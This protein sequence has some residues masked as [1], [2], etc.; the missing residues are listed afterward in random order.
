MQPLRSGGPLQLL[1]CML[2]RWAAGP[3]PS[4][5]APVCHCRARCLQI[6]PPSTTGFLLGQ[7][8]DLG[9]KLTSVVTYHILPTP[10]SPDQVTQ[11]G[12]LGAA[13]EGLEGRSTAGCS[14]VAAARWGAPPGGRRRLRA[15][16]EGP[17]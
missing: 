12:A 4:M 10:V 2:V 1:W 8:S 3:L 5:A 11:Q 13:V 6:R 7:L 14:R 16:R 15:V 9:D 17:A